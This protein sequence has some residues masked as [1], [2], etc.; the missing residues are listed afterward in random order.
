MEKTKYMIMKIKIKNLTG[1]TMG[2]SRI[3]QV[4]DFKYLW[5]T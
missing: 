5:M 1:I 4:R 2:N 3:E